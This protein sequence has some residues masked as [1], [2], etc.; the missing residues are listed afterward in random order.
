MEISQESLNCGDFYFSLNKCGYNGDAVWI[1]IQTFGCLP[2]LWG[3]LINY[4]NTAV[5]LKLR[6]NLSFLLWVRLHYTLNPGLCDLQ[7][8]QPR[9]VGNLDLITMLAC[10]CCIIQTRVW[11]SAS[12]NMCCCIPGFLVPEPADATLELISYGLWENLSVHSLG[13]DWKCFGWF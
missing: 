2:T 6:L 10:P 3:S 9:C 5:I 8:E 12:V 1:N 11:T 13:V 4:E 7:I